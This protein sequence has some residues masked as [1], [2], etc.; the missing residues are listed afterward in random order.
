[1]EINNKSA[2]KFEDSFDSSQKIG[3]SQDSFYE[4]HKIGLSADSI[5]NNKGKKASQASTVSIKT[6]VATERLHLPKIAL[7]IIKQ[8]SLDE[9]LRK[10]KKQFSKIP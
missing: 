8:L 9:E 4:F 6:K 5:S 10:C 2:S 7:E 3:F 1:M